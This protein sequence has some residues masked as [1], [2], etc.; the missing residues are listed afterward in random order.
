MQGKIIITSWAVLCLCA[1]SAMATVVSSPGDLSSVSSGDDIVINNGGVYN[2]SVLDNLNLNSINVAFIGER[3]NPPTPGVIFMADAAFDGELGVTLTKKESLQIR[4]S[5]DYLNNATITDNIVLRFTNY[6]S[7]H[8]TGGRPEA[9]SENTSDIYTYDFVPCPT[10]TGYCVVRSLT[11]SYTENQNVARYAGR[12]A[13][14]GVQNNPTMLLRPMITIN[15]YELVGMYDFGDDTYLSVSPEYYNA[16]NMYNVGAR[17][18]AGTRIGAGL[19]VGVSGYATRAEFKNDVSGFN[20]N[21]YGGNLRLHYRLDEVLF[22]RGVGGVTMA[23]IDCDD[24]ADG[25][26]RVNNPGAFSIYGG[27]DFGAIFNF[28]SGLYL[29]P[30]IGYA[31]SSARIVD[32]HEND[33]F[34]HLGNDIGFKYFMDGVS[35]SYALRTGINSNG[36]FDAGVGIAIM[37]VNDKIGGT[38]S[39]GIM[40]TDFGWTGKIAANIRFAF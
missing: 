24:V 15:N 30:F 11:V 28:E 22:L 34:G 14:A 4:L 40:D 13:R 10:G 12:V 21:V 37:S 5:N 18:N 33:N 29:S 23:D 7:A 19:T 8:S 1:S 17:L 3:P 20:A 39:F 6:D 27:A 31:A 16:K 32:V 35:Y 9:F 38:V 25:D 26:G 2:L 36:Y